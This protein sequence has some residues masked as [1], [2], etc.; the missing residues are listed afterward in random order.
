M[1]DRTRG[2]RHASL[3]L[4]LVRE[5][6][7][8]T[9][10]GTAATPLE[11]SPSEC[12][13]GSC[14]CTGHMEADCENACGDTMSLSLAM[15]GV[16]GAALAAPSGGD[17]SDCEGGFKCA[18]EFGFASVGLP[19][20]IAEMAGGMLIFSCFSSASFASLGSAPSM[21]S[22]CGA[23]TSTRTKGSKCGSRCERACV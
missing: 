18:C 8:C 11:S 6:D 12:R 4:S 16:A 13:D 5:S 23:G 17:R 1:G 10:H 15:L 2:V 19:E 7:A 14:A 21:L 9:G 20:L 3:E 22:S